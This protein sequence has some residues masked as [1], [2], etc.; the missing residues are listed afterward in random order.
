MWANMTWRAEH[1]QEMVFGAFTPT[2]TVRV[3][4]S[5]EGQR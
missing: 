5:A 3:A 2:D 4:G 1:A